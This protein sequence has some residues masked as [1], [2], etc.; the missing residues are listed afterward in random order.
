MAKYTCRLLND[1]NR[2]DDVETFHSPSHER[3]QAQ[4]YKLLAISSLANF[5]LW[6]DK[7]LICR[8]GAAPAGKSAP[9]AEAPEQDTESPS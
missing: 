1:D 9:V 5:E 6:L 4:A 3:A 2:I 7:R 8:S